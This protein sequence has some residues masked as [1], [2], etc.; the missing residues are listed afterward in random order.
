MSSEVVITINS[1]NYT[2][3]AKSV[4]RAIKNTLIKVQKPLTKSRQ[5]G[6]N[7]PETLAVDIK[8]ITDMLTIVGEIHYQEIPDASAVGAITGTATSGGLTTLSD[9]S[10]SWTTNQ[11]TGFVVLITGGTGVNQYRTIISNT[12]TQITVSSKWGTNPS[13]DSTYVISPTP[14]SVRAFNLL[15]TAFKTRPGPYTIVYRGVTYS[16]L[17]DMLE[18]EDKADTLQSYVSSANVRSAD[19]PSK[20]NCTISFTICTVK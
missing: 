20:V 6:T 7:V 9:T 16:G 12:T 8:R 15:A 19:I 18:S 10:K 14:N 5:D 11:Y 2:I 1:V 4:K 17:F 3:R 13:S